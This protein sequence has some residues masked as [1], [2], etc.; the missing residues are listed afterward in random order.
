V[1]DAGAAAIV[2]WSPAGCRKLGAGALERPTGVAIQG[3]RIWVTDPPRHQLVA[4]STDGAVVARIGHH[5]DGD[6]AFSY[7]SAVAAT[8]EGLL[9]VDALNFRIVRLD[10]EGR[11]LGAFGMAGEE[12]G[13]F[14]L[15]KAVSSDESG[16]VYVSD[17]QRDEVLVFSA[18]GDFQYG[19]GKTGAESG[20]FTHPAGV[21]VAKG[22]IVVADSQNRRVQVFEILGDA[23]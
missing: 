4:L 12:P 18:G 7:P 6:G 16:R 9:V 17:A 22:R 19:I 3:S 11:W 8:A 13:T 1:A 23:S 20:R 15:P 21:A 10:A 14:L 5:G 2:H